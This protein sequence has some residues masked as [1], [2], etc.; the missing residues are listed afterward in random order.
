MFPA[1]AGVF[2]TSA[3]WEAVSPGCLFKMQILGFQNRFMPSEALQ[4]GP[5]QQLSLVEHNFRFCLP[6]FPVTITLT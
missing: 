2:T 3:T 6:S 5:A 4:W 1:L